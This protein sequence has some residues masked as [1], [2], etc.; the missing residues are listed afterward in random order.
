MNMATSFRNSARTRILNTAADLFYSRGINATGIDLII[1]EAGVAKASLY[2]NFD[3][4]E[5]LV[6]AYLEDLRCE[7][8]QGLAS[9]IE[10]RGDVLDIPFDLLERSV[11]GGRFFGC[12]FTN[13][14]TEL[15]TSELV[16]KEV[17][18]YRSAVRNF[19]QKVVAS[20]EVVDQLMLVY[21]GAFISCKLSPDKKN[22]LAARNLARKIASLS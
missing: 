10:K 15:P 4:K 12:P 18:A 8:E 2:N 17:G 20:T 9:E 3:S 7:F 11:M 1:A 13:A 21:D 5:A 6:A 22:V 14:L 19:F 16:K